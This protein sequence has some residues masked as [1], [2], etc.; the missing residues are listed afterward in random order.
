MKVQPM[1]GK[2]RL[3]FVAVSGKHRTRSE[4]NIDI[5]SPNPRTIE[6]V[7]KALAPGETFEQKVMPHGLAGTNE[8]TLEVSSIRPLNLERRLDYL[9]QYPHGCVEQTTSSVFPQ[10]Y[11]STL[12]KLDEQ[13]KRA[14]DANIRA[15][16][17]RLR[18]FQ[19]A[20]GGFT[21]WPGS[22]ANFY[23]DWASNYAG[24]FLLQA[25]KLGYTVPPQMLNDWIA[26][27]KSLAQ[28]WTARGG[29]SMMEQA[30]RLYT[31]AEVNQPALGAMNRLRET[32][33][34]TNVVRWQLAAAYK[35]A[36]HRD[37]AEQLVRGLQP[38][39]G[40][41]AEPGPTFGS[42][43]RDRAIILNSLIALG[44]LDHAGPVSRAISDE[45]ASGQ[46]YSTQ[47]LAYSLMSMGRLAGADKSGNAFT[48]EQG[49][50]S[51]QLKPV[52]S[53]KPVH[54]S[55]LASFPDTG[56]TLRVHNTS[57]K[58]IFVQVTTKGAPAAGEEKTAA[59]GLRLEV[60]YVDKAGN[61]I[62]PN[63][64]DQG[65]DYVAT[66][67]V[68]N[69]SERKL[70]NLALSH[71]VPSGW[72]LHNAR[73]GSDQAKAPEGID[74]QDIRDDRVYSYFTIAAHET[75]TVE[76]SFNASYQGNY[77]LPAVSVEA[78]YDATK[79]AQSRGQWVK[80]VKSGR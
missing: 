60:K 28:A 36:G 20:G 72:E 80:V 45:L 16:I 33:A 78:M 54:T 18:L 32:P 11:L 66:V 5:R 59:A 23:N 55:R 6:V 73:L 15:G 58:P 52:Q 21:Y 40:D 22:A 10:L 51:A 64:L 68:T 1:L 12:V 25:D 39:A 56:D 29:D 47:S 35:L 53:D 14:I 61:T 3:R 43:L 74:Y 62:Q 8:V 76:V 50:G 65:V 19:I 42:K 2:G 37:A 46:W 77:Y 26:H 4:I 41:Y 69:L 34:L 63:Q 75:K 27:Q 49:V 7:E 13:K 9:I 48:F 57:E 24:H 44:D 79:H 71:I 17:D 30:Y 38:V 31:L 70:E 67:T